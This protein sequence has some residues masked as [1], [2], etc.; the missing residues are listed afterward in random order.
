LKNV[1]ERAIILGS[2][3]AG[4]EVDPH[5]P[6]EEVPAIA[7]NGLESSSD[8][9]R[10]DAH[11]RDSGP[12]SPASGGGSPFRLPTTGVDLEEVER[13]FIRQALEM[14][15]GNQTK[16]SEALGLTR[17]ALRYRMKKFGFL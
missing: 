13:D 8:Q 9:E 16:A 4:G 11:E 15:Q 17:D 5:L 3:T 6:G 14:T 12:I 10:F 7:S 2:D 1:I